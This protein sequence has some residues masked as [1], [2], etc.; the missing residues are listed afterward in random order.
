M[1]MEEK[2]EYGDWLTAVSEYMPHPRQKI[3]FSFIHSIDPR[4]SKILAFVIN[5]SFNVLEMSEE[6]HAGLENN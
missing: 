2:R 4:N 1:R 3:I 5:G 6:E